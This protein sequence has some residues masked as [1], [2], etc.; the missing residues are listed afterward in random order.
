MLEMARHSWV[1][2]VFKRSL[3]DTTCASGSEDNFAA[4]AVCVAAL[5]A[6]KKEP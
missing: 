3:R 5:K 2:T 1:A 4:K 6:I